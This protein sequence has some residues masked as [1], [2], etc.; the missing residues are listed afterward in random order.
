MKGRGYCLLILLAVFWSG[1]VMGAD[2]ASPATAYR[3][4]PGDKI[5]I[6]E[7]MP[8]R[9]GR[10]FDKQDVV[11]T[12]DGTVQLAGLGQPM[13]LTGLT[14]AEA[15]KAVD[16]A[17]RDGKVFVILSV[18]ISIKDYAPRRVKVLGQVLYPGAVE[19]PKDKPLTAIKAISQVGGLTPKSSRILTLTRTLPDGKTTSQPIDFVDAQ[20]D[21]SKD[22]PLQD[23]DILTAF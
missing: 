4:R 11:I 16:A 19:I 10:A 21:P 7:H 6:D 20:T 8:P 13:K 3:L 12:K 2:A 1:M 5:T 18:S 15:A 23:G 14:L 17:Y 22:L 9:W